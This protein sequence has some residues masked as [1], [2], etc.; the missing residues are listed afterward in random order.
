MGTRLTGKVSRCGRRVSRR[1][2]LRHSQLAEKRR[3]LA[4][5]TKLLVRYPIPTHQTFQHGGRGVYHLGGVLED[6][7]SG[8]FCA[9]GAK[10]DP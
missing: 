4:S 3:F 8:T 10:T 7:G 5:A 1:H 2:D 6:D 9:G